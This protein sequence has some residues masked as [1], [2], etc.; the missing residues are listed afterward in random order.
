MRHVLGALVVSLLLAT[1]P[2][3]SAQEG[4]PVTE[5][6]ATPV[7]EQLTWVLAQLNGDAADLTEADIVDH[8]AP[9]FLATFLPAPV[10]L[11]LLRQTSEQYAPVTFTGFAF[12]PT[13]T[14]AV[15]PVD[16][17]TGE[18]AAIYLVVEPDPPHRIVRM[19]L[20]EAPAP[21]SATGK[22]VSIG[23]RALYLDCA[24]EGAPTVVLEGGIT[25]DWAMVQ[26]GVTSSTRVCAYDRPD[27]PGS[28]S[29]P[30]AQR[31]AQE[32]VDDLSALL[33]AAGEAGPYVLVGHSMGGLYVQLYAYQHPDDV[34]GLVLVDPTPEEFSARLADLLTSLGTPVPTPPPD[35]ELSIDETAFQ[36]LREARATGD[37][38]AV[39]MIV[40]THGLPDDPAERPPGWPLAD[41]E[42]IFRELHAEIAAL[43][44]NSRLL[45]AEQS[46]HN[47]HQE[48]PQIVIE[49]IL[50]AVEA[51][52][53]PGTWATPFATPAS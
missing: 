3:V 13:D 50:D 23:E 7:G 19:D 48:Q 18:Q 37:L 40:L 25:S 38:P 43:V 46:R 8:F 36:Q 4:T 11:D 14:S 10:L 32:V 27:S 21:P 33:D 9:E 44:P 30:T 12:P 53:D 1:G 31:T 17:A 41:E 52:R 2:R 35:A 15:T 26:P 42:R 20:S 24:G 39:P 22:R 45:I 51:V 47:I 6:P 34:A 5:I 29:D 16:V 49:S 28:R